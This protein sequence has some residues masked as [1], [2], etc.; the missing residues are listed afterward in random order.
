ML[1]LILS[2]G[3]NTF[4]GIYNPITGEISTIGVDKADRASTVFWSPDQI[5]SLMLPVQALYLL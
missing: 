3:F 1:A 4:I 2:D 5:K